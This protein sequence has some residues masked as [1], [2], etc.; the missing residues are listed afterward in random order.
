MRI[1]TKIKFSVEDLLQ[2]ICVNKWKSIVCAVAAIAGLVVGAVFVNVFSYSWWY[3]NRCNYA[4]S[5]FEGGFGLFFS[6]LLWTAVYFLC[7][8]MCNV[9]PSTKYLSCAALFA[10]CFYCG[11]NTMAAILYWSVWGVLFALLVTAVEVVGY[12]AACLVTCCEPSCC[13]TLKEAFCDAKLCFW[14]LAAAFLVKIVCFFV[15][16]RIITAV[17]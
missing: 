15:I 14:V 5:L 4:Y 16:L 10:A 7:L 1:F 6:F 17:I 9:F 3:E 12:F 11:A 13:R 8:A 2:K